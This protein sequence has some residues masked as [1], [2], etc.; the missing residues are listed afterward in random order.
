MPAAGKGKGAAVSSAPLTKQT[1][2]TSSTKATTAAATSTDRPLTAAQKRAAA[3]PAEPAAAEESTTSPEHKKSRSTRSAPEKAAAPELE[4]APSRSKTSRVRS[5]PKPTPTPTTTTTDTASSSS[6]NV[7]PTSSSTSPVR[8]QFRTAVGVSDKPATGAAAVSG[9]FSADYTAAASTAT[10]GGDPH[11]V[12]SPAH[13][14][15]SR[16]SATDKDKAAPTGP[17]SASFEPPA[18]L[19]SKT[20]DKKPANTN[21]PAFI[22]S[23]RKGPCKGQELILPARPTPVK[24]AAKGKK[25]ASAT[26]THTVGKAPDCDFP[27]TTDIYLSDR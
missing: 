2:A 1:A 25:A 26:S 7:R 12:L 14:T 27:L 4:A 19:R 10:T 18:N 20:A 23:I 11:A 13:S 16:T 5:P 9:P 15:R 6:V 24:R 8:K 21:P 17:F 3:K 22:F